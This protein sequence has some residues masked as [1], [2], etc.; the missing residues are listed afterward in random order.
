MRRLLSMKFR[1][2]QLEMLSTLH[3]L[4]PSDVLRFEG[5]EEKHWI[6]CLGNLLYKTSQKRSHIPISTN[7][8]VSWTLLGLF[9]AIL[10]LCWRLLGRLE[11]IWRWSWDVCESFWRSIGMSCRFFKPIWAVLGRQGGVLGSPGR[12]FLGQRIV[13]E[14][15]WHALCILKVCEAFSETDLIDCLDVNASEVVSIGCKITIDFL[16]VFARF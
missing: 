9:R 1:N 4:T 3:R 8:K 6:I 14:A 11:G 15:M 12:A 16:Y 7:L 10:E 2:W 13:W 5:C